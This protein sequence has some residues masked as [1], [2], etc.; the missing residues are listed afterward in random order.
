MIFEFLIIACLTGW[1]L[2]AGEWNTKDY[3]K[4]DHSLVK[5]YNDDRWE[6]VGSTIVTNT[7][8]R[9]TPDHQSRKGAIW[10][11]VPCHM[12]D[13]ELH[14]HFKVHGKGDGMFGDGFAIWYTKDRS[15]LGP[16]FGSKDFFSGLAVLLDSYNNEPGKHKH[17]HPYISAMV[18]NGSWHYDH[19]RDGT[20]TELAGCESQFRGAAHETF[21]AVRYEHDKLT[22]SM[23]IEGKNAWQ[24]CFAVEGIKLPT[25]Y[26]FGASAATGELADNHDIISIKLYDIAVDPINDGVDRSKILPSAD[27]F[28]A[29][30]D[31]I[32]EGQGGSTSS[33]GG[34]W[35]TFFLVIFVLLLLAACAGGG[36]Y[37]Y[38]KSREKKRLY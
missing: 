35:S 32:H 38:M 16:V 13:W 14:V 12:R 22:I 5:P 23:D 28:A 27:N 37:L 26:Y 11:K 17:T 10:N 9:L 31:H 6:Y 8:V 30:R 25:G 1:P 2:V 29:P 20:H 15:E 4:K 19:D 3:L 36:Y 34:G 21:I 18:N 24:Q 33:G 7:Y